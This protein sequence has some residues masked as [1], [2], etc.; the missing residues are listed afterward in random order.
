M[1]STASNICHSSVTPVSSSSNVRAMSAI[2]ES[3]PL[4]FGTSTNTRVI[5]I[6]RWRSKKISCKFRVISLDNPPPYVALSYTWGSLPANETIILDGVPV[7]V[8]LNLLQF[9][10]E[11][12]ARHMFLSVPLLWVDAICIDQSRIAER[13]HQVSIM[14]DIYSK[15]KHIIT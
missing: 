15:A 4:S 13:N 5:E 7:A 9:L 14:G 6:H 12:R 10:L 11:F 1:N 3:V 2:Y 8:R